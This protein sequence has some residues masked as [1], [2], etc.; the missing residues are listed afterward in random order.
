M[1]FQIMQVLRGMR[2]CRN[3]VGFPAKFRVLFPKSAHVVEILVT[4][5]RSRALSSCL[6]YEAILVTTA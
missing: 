3:A 1:F 2:E 6:A 5:K 4:L